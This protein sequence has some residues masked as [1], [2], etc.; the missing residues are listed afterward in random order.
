MYFPV[1][2]VKFP[3]TPI[4]AKHL[5]W[6]LLTLLMRFFVNKGMYQCLAEVVRNLIT[7]VEGGSRQRVPEI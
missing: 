2:F 3:R 6:L 5:W 7:T 4:F 1:N